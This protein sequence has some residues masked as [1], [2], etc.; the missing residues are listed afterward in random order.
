M[1]EMLLLLHSPLGHGLHHRGYPA[2]KEK[3]MNVIARGDAYAKFN[4]HCTL[5]PSWFRCSQLNHESPCDAFND[6]YFK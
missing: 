1:L 6:M 2:Y 5:V 3:C 4:A